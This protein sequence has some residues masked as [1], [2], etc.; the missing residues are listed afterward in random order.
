M[1]AI[2]RIGRECFP[3]SPERLF[4]YQLGDGFLVM[5]E[6]G[7]EYLER[8]VTI[9]AALMQ[10]VAASGRLTKAAIAE[11]ELSGIQG[12]YP[13]EVLNELEGDHNVS[14]KMGIMTIFPVM[15]TALIRSVKVA[16][17]SPSGP[18]LTIEGSK[19]GRIPASVPIQ[20]IEGT[21]LVAIDWVHMHTPLLTRIQRQ[22]QLIA[23]GA[24]KLEGIIARYCSK[25][26]LK[27]EW[28][29]NVRR[30]LKII[31]NDIPE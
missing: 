13:Q 14:L 4:A 9:A 28:V 17:A 12:C 16:K 24:N 27:P 29:L 23:P 8:S 11:G 21:D 20:S 7:E 1:C 18:L 25:Y 6:F 19:T 3:D 15:G 31:G 30:Y 5:S 26:P 2:F 22:A 10:H